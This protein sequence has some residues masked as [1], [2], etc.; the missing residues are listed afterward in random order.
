MTMSLKKNVLLGFLA[1]ILFT[2]IILT[3]CRG[4]DMRPEKALDNFSKLIEKGN[5]DDLNLTI[6]YYGVFKL[7]LYPQSKDELINETN[8]TKIIV[9]GSDLK[10]HLNLFNLLRS[11]ALIPVEQESRIDAR[12]YYV[13]ETQKGRR[14]FDVTMWGSN[15]YSIFVN[16]VEFKENDIFYDIIIPFLPDKEAEELSN[17]LGRNSNINE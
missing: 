3:I 9:S 11:D 5:I 10:K 12:I 13:F 2:T 1:L 7:T 4:N 17:F 15:D 6:Y 16:G 8:R 14:A